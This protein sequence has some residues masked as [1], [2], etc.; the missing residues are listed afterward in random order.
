MKEKA[1][2]WKKID[3]I[4]VSILI[5]FIVV[6]LILSVVFTYYRSQNKIVNIFGYSVCYVISGSMEPALEVGDAILIKDVAAE[7]IEVG[8]VITFMS[9]SGQLAGAYITHRVTSITVG[10]NYFFTTKGDANSVADSEI[11]SFDQIEGVYQQKLAIIKAAISIL[12][13]PY[14]FVI[15]VVTPLIVSLI[16]QMVAFIV[17]LQ[18]KEETPLLEDKKEDDETNKK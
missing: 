1:S 3:K 11:V 2:M 12:D 16:M 4:L 13:N 15:F 18:E 6:S 5:S 9:Q 7:D 10:E 17:A 8:D 14:I